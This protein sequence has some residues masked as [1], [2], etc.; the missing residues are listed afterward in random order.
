MAVKSPFEIY[1]DMFK[2]WGDVFG[3]WAKSGKSFWNYPEE[4]S[5]IFT[6]LTE[7]MK[8]FPLS[9]EAIK[10]YSEAAAKG[11]N[12][13]V[14]IYD[15][16]VKS[17]DKIGRKQFEMVQA[18]AAGE[19]VKTTELF[20]IL[21]ESSEDISRNLVESVRGSVFNGAFKGI[22]EIN[23]AFKQFAD[24]FSAEEKQAKETFQ[25][26]SNAFVKIVKSWNTLMVEAGKTFSDM[27]GKGEISPDTYKKVM[28]I[29]GEALKESVDALFGP[30]SNLLPRYKDLVNDV[31]DW[32]N[33]YFDLVT[34][35]L[36]VFLKFSQGIGK[37]SSEIYKFIDETLKESKSASIEEFNKKWFEFYGKATADLMEAIQL[38]VTLPKFTNSLVE[39]IKA[40]NNLYQRVMIPP[41]PSKEEMDKVYSNIEKVRKMA[42][43]KGEEKKEEG[44]DE[45]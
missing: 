31:T 20:D 37:S 3:P 16:W 11:I 30:L 24:S 40:T 22:E 43:K 9:Y 2:A 42:E 39:Y 32:T 14:K 13:Y 44:P 19:E 10:D 1:T 12:A 17:M 38:S 34:S 4:W 25:A 21:R 18:I 28:I 29:Y 45:G 35:W 6:S 8:G 7:A 26:F 15:A 5:K 27:L 33:K 36:E 41:F 23:K